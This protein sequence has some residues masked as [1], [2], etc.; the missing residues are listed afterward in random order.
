MTKKKSSTNGTNKSFIDLIRD[1]VETTGRTLNKWTGEIGGETVDMYA[2][3]LTPLDIE[4]VTNKYDNLESIP[5]MTFLVCLKAVDEEGRRLFPVASGAYKVVS[6][7][8]LS[9]LSD[10]INALI[11]DDISAEVDVDSAEKN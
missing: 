11:G 2:A 1:E 3:P 10:I 9:I 6:Q 8:P 4:K 7:L 5:A